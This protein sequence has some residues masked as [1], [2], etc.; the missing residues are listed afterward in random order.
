[1][2]LIKYA[3]FM[4]VFCMN[5]FTVIFQASGQY[6]ATSLTHFKNSLE[7]LMHG[8]YEKAIAACNQVLRQNPNSSVTLT[9]RARAFYEMGDFDRA[10]ADTTQ[11]IRLDRN[12]ISAYN[13]RGNAHVKRGNYDRAIAD[14]R[15]VLRIN[16]DF[17]EVQENLERALQRQE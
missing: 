4:A 15:A 11:A 1:M 7:F 17:T 8:E 14:W 13:I 2:R 9:I 10:I 16:P 5:L 3:V 6:H 12:N